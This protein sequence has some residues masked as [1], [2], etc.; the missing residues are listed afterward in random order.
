MQ[1]RLTAIDLLAFA[2]ADNQPNKFLHLPSDDADLQKALSRLQDVT[3][4]ECLSSGVAYMHE[5][6]AES[7][8]KIV[9]SLFEAGAI[10][11]TC[12]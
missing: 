9:S 5:G 10:Q 4:R 8:A 3:L 6:V 11:V 12:L 7:D 1:S 2:A